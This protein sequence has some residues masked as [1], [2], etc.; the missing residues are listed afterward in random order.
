MLRLHDPF[1]DV[2]GCTHAGFLCYTWARNPCGLAA[3]YIHRPP[4]LIMTPLSIRWE[5]V[6]TH[7]PCGDGILPVEIEWVRQFRSTPP[8]RRTGCLQISGSGLLSNTR[9]IARGKKRKGIYDSFVTHELGHA[10]GIG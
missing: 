9:A 8:T 1:V 5:N 10:V 2:P 7:V 4:P 6:I 3:S